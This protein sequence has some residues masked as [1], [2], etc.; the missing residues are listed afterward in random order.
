MG[1]GTKLL[2]HCRGFWKTS[3]WC[4]L[5]W[6]RLAQAGAFIWMW[7]I[8]SFNCRSRWPVPNLWLLSPYSAA[9]SAWLPRGE[10][11]LPADTEA[12][13]AGIPWAVPGAAGHRLQGKSFRALHPDL[14]SVSTIYHY[15]FKCCT[16]SQH[17]QTEHTVRSSGQPPVHHRPLNTVVNL[18]FVW[19]KYVLFQQ[20]HFFCQLLI[21]LWYCQEMENSFSLW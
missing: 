2:T 1:R 16:G 14:C 6:A 21:F 5:S 13:G 10:A 11:F 7:W 3:A 4:H 12:L 15:L 17:S 18:L 9:A 20:K 8:L 19:L